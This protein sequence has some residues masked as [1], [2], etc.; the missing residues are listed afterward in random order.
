MKFKLR[1]FD[2]RHFFIAH[3]HRPAFKNVIALQA[4]FADKSPV[5][6]FSYFKCIALIKLGAA[7]GAAIFYLSHDSPPHSFRYSFYIFLP[8]LQL[9]NFKRMGI[10]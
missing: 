4:F 8:T 6:C 9:E 1:F 10:Q 7:F 3:T 2:H 5:T